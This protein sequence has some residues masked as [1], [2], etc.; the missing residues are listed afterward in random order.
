MWK[1]AGFFQVGKNLWKLLLGK[2][3]QKCFMNSRQN[4]KHVIT[5][6]IIKSN[7]VIT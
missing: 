1:Y 6:N 7:I 4:V 2:E 5:W 3:V